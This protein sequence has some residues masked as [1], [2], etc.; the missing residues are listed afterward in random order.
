V[1]C[2]LCVALCGVQNN[3]ALDFQ[4]RQYR[5]LLACSL[6]PA[7]PEL[8]SATEAAAID[9]ASASDSASNAAAWRHSLLPHTADPA[10]PSASLEPHDCYLSLSSFNATAMDE[11]RFTLASSVAADLTDEQVEQALTT[12]ALQQQ[13]ATTTLLQSMRVD[14]A[15]AAGGGFVRLI[16]RACA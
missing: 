6:R 7:S 13:A 8:S 14:V 16:Q 15:D 2:L 10:L 9:S 5:L 11:A 1:L 12:S 3:L 4:L